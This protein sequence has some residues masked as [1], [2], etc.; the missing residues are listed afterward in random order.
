MMTLVVTVEGN[1]CPWLGHHSYRCGKC[2]KGFFKARSDED[3]D[4][5]CP[6]CDG[7][8]HAYLEWDG[9]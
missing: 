2:R 7:Y 4:M 3:Y 1:R 8:V 5:K 6:E 9:K